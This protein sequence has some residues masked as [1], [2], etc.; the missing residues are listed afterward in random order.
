MILEY[1]SLLC[2]K[3]TVILNINTIPILT[4][5]TYVQEMLQI[6]QNINLRDKL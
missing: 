6:F 2:Q 5:V 1:W 4:S 3:I